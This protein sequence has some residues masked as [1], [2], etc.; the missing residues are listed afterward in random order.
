[1]KRDQISEVFEIRIH[2]GFGTF[3]RIKKYTVM[4]QAEQDAENLFSQMQRMGVDVGRIELRDEDDRLCVAHFF[5]EAAD[6]AAEKRQQ[7][8]RRAF[9]EK[10]HA[11][12]LDSDDLRV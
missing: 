2:D 3:T 4:S 11:A 10:M 5:T 12:G 6:R 1:M 7:A 9:K 8:R